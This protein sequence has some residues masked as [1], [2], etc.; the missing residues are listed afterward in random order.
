[1]FLERKITTTDQVAL[2]DNLW[3]VF[4]EFNIPHQKTNQ[5]IKYKWVLQ[6]IVLGNLSIAAIISSGSAE[7]IST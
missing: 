2:E 5:Q 4:P 3:K 6:L 1:M 7:L